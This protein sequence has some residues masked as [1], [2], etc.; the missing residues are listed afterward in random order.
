[1][2]KMKR[3][4][5]HLC[6]G[7]DIYECSECGNIQADL[8]KNGPP[9]CEECEKTSG[10]LHP[11]IRWRLEFFEEGWKKWLPFEDGI[12]ETK[13]DVYKKYKEALYHNDKVRIIEEKVIEST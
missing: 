8:I 5:D 13:D 9:A 4:A 6:P 2:T 11:V 12:C 1:M 3:I 10:S 7:V